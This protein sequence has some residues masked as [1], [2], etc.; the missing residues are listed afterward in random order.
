MGGGAP[1]CV[2]LH[3]LVIEKKIGYLLSSAARAA[4][5]GGARPVAWAPQSKFALFLHELG[6]EDADLVARISALGGPPNP[7]NDSTLVRVESVPLRCLLDPRW[8][9]EEL[10]A[11][12]ELQAAAILPAVRALL[13]DR[14]VEA[15]AMALPSPEAAPTRPIDV[16]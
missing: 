10:H 11:F 2:A 3:S 14:H 6:P 7:S 15:G 5:E 4:I 8:R 12:A 13:A 1:P 16:T 9:R